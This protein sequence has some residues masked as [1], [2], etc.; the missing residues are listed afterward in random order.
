MLKTSIHALTRTPYVLLCSSFVWYLYIVVTFASCCSSLMW[1][2]ALVMSLLVGS[3]LVSSSYLASGKTRFV[4]FASRSKWGILRLYL[5]PFC[6]SSYSA[7]AFTQGFIGAFPVEHPV[8]GGIGIAVASA[9]GLIL[10]GIHCA[11]RECHTDN[12][13]EDE[14]KNPPPCAHRDE[15]EP[16]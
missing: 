5:I 10:A 9:V 14:G 4:E 1:V 2:N 3:V 7:V 6:V 12:A 11:T 13:S 8:L 15:V 16:I